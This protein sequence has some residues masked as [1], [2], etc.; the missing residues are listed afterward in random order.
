MPLAVGGRIFKGGRRA[1]TPRLRHPGRGRAP[2]RVAHRMGAGL[3]VTAD[4]LGRVSMR[5]LRPTSQPDCCSPREE[6][7]VSVSGYKYSDS[8]PTRRVR[9]PGCPRAVTTPRRR[10]AET[11]DELA[12]LP[13]PG[14]HPTPN[15][16]K[17]TGNSCSGIFCKGQKPSTTLGRMERTLEPRDRQGPDALLQTARGGWSYGTK[18]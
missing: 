16:A 9:S 3:S 15:G 17:G 7:G 13:S 11:N 1:G 4:S 5:T 6:G 14:M 2:G 10:A 8:T 18:G 12:P